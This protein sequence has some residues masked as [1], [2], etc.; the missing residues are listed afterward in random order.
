MGLVH[1]GWSVVALVG[2]DALRQLPD[3]DCIGPMAEVVGKKT[4]G[5]HKRPPN[6]NQGSGLPAAPE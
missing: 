3:R 6:S 5:R 1:R 2:L 4:G